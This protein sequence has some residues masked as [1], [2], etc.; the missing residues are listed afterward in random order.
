[1]TRRA[2]F[3]LG[4][5]LGQRSL[6]ELFE[7]RRTRMQAWALLVATKVVADHIDEDDERYLL[8]ERLVMHFVAEAVTAPMYWR[9]WEE[10]NNPEAREAYG[11]ALGKQWLCYEL[12]EEY[13]N[14][15][16]VGDAESWLAAMADSMASYE[17]PSSVE[18]IR[19]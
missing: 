7:L 5:A 18:E 1:M 16:I 10:D 13:V 9:I 19:P 11:A 17:L 4:P 2:I 14:E 6:A 15:E 3:D 8:F 12:L